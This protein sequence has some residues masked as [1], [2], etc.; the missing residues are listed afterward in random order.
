MDKFSEEIFHH[1][2]KNY[3]L[4]NYVPIQHAKLWGQG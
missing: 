1:Y 2:K 3:N 4:F